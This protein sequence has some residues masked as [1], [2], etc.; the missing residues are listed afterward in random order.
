MEPT[1]AHSFKTMIKNEFSFLFSSWWLSTWRC[2]VFGFIFSTFVS[3]GYLF[4]SF[5]SDSFLLISLFIL[6]LGTYNGLIFGLLGGLTWSSYKIAGPWMFVSLL[7]ISTAILVSFTAM[8]SIL[9]EQ[10]EVLASAIQQASKQHE[11]LLLKLD[12]LTR[13]GPIILIIAIPLLLLDLSFIVFDLAVFW[14]VIVLMLY[15]I[16]ILLTGFIPSTILSTV[17]ALLTYAKRFKPR[18]PPSSP[19][20]HS[21]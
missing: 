17:L 11:W 13:V 9:T 19:L 1:P 14:H 7:L 16:G 18:Y 15:F 8:S 6:L 5:P 20:N 21:P 3:F 4:T 10:L 12:R 2:A